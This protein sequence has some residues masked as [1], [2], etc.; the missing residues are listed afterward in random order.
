MTRGD[1]K[2]A[3]AKRGWE[4]GTTKAQV[5][6]ATRG[7]ATTSRRDDRMRGRRAQRED[8]E[9]IVV[10]ADVEGGNVLVPNPKKRRVRIPRIVERGG[11]KNK[12]KCK[13]KM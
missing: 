11:D 4:G 13:V 5:G 1:A 10:Y 2:S 9:R 12:Q 3:G 6:G 7:D 8:D